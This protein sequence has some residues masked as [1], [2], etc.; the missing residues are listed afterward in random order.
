M[1]RYRNQLPTR[2][3]PELVHQNLANY[4]TSQGFRVIDARQNVW[5][6]GMGLM[7]G[8]Q[9]IRYESHPGHLVLEAW[10]KF[11]LLPG[12]YLGE[13]GIDGF[14]AFIPKKM[15]KGR[16]VDIERISTAALT[17]PRKPFAPT[18]L[19]R[20]IVAGINEDRGS[21]FRWSGQL[22]GAAFVEAVRPAR[23]HRVL[24]QNLA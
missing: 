18:P 1:A 15:L 21:P 9:F 11:A 13:M 22:D 4:L 23:A 16:M 3:P 5:Q 8:P 7:L 2:L 19:H 12:V 24:P 14:F 6:K 20:F 10:I 17:R